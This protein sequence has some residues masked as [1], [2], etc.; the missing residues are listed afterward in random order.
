MSKSLRHSLV[1][2]WQLMPDSVRS[3]PA[4]EQELE[5]FESMFG[6]IPEDYRWF[7]GS[8]GGGPVGSEW[9]DDIKQLKI[10]HRKFKDESG[11][12]GWT[13]KDVFVIG[14]DG[15]GNPFGI[16]TSNGK[17]LVEDHNFGGVHQMAD[18]FIAFLVD[19][20]INNP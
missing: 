7:L 9:V 5:E 17:V 11:P 13:M 3:T 2:A 12:N 1:E 20:L 6:S 4:T 14:W 16:Q 10:S 19:G 8:C 15:G 18:S